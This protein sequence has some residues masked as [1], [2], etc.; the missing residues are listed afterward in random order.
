MNNLFNLFSLS[1]LFV[2][3]FTF[4]EVSAGTGTL[5]T[6]VNPN[7]WGLDNTIAGIVSALGAYLVGLLTKKRE[8]KRKKKDD[9]S[10][11]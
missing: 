3:A 5:L 2:F 10:N 4:T 11:I 9:L 6:V 1:L 8:K 7:N